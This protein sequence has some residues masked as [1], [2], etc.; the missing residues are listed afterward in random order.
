M[1]LTMN[2]FTLTASASSVCS[3]VRI[4][5]IKSVAVLT[6]SFFGIDCRWADATQNVFFE[7]AKSKMFDIHAISI[8][9]QVVN[10]DTFR[11]G[12]V[13]FFPKVSVDK[14]QSN[15]GRHSM[16][17][18]RW[19]SVFQGMASIGKFYEPFRDIFIRVFSR[20]MPIPATLA[21]S[22]Y[23]SPASI[24]DLSLLSAFLTRYKPDSSAMLG[25]PKKNWLF[26]QSCND[27]F[28]FNH[29]PN[30]ISAQ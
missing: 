29:K 14:F 1:E 22:T 7:R 2:S 15:I 6:V 13:N 30:R 5:F 23:S 25:A 21:I 19:H 17:M 24:N 11:Y 18:R 26:I 4:S 12:S 10:R 9:A 8:S 27:A 16:V 28:S 20:T 3:M